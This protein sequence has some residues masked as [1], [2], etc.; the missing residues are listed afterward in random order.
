[1]KTPQG[2]NEWDELS[3]ASSLLASMKRTDGG[4]E[5]LALAGTIP[6]TVGEKLAR[7]RMVARVRRRTVG[8]KEG[9]EHALKI[10][11]RLFA[12]EVCWRAAEASWR[13]G[14]DAA[15]H[16][17]F[18]A[19]LNDGRPKLTPE[20]RQRR[21]KEGVQARSQRLSAIA[22]RELA[23]ARKKLTAAQALVRRAE[24]LVRKWGERV[25]YHQQRGRLPEEDG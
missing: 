19:W 12:D 21:L 24:A 6:L 3:V 13:L 14:G 23:A 16:P 17:L 5:V 15:L 2:R 11:K 9:R 25:K 10:L 22:V 1:V 8:S 20:E 7:A 18:R 4:R